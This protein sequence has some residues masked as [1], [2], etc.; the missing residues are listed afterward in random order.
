MLINRIINP[1][2]RVDDIT[3]KSNDA[4]LIISPIPFSMLLNPS[5]KLLTGLNLLT[6]F[7]AS[8]ISAA[9]IFKLAIATTIIVTMDAKRNNVPVSQ[10]VDNFKKSFQEYMKRNI[11]T[12]AERNLAIIPVILF[13]FI[14][15]AAS[16]AGFATIGFYFAT[17]STFIIAYIFYLVTTFYL[18]SNVLDEWVMRKGEKEA[19]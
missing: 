8:P 10:Q 14:A 12:K 3:I 17:E 13:G 1:L 2:I 16:F 18:I 7:L 9:W 6:L 5:I 4:D 15:V 19:L 11:P